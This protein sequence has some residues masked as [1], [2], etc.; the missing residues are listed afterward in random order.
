MIPVT[1]GCAMRLSMPPK[2][3]QGSGLHLNITDKKCS[4]NGGSMS[5]IGI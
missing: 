4:V 2:R 3:D 1:G 5:T